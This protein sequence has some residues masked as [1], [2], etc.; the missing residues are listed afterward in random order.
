V[1]DKSTPPDDA[2]VATVR[3]A[4]R[5]KLFTL[6]ACERPFHVRVNVTV[7][8]VGAGRLQVNLRSVI[9]KN[10]GEMV[11][12]IPSKLSAEHTAP[13]DRAAKE[14]EILKQGGESVALLF[15]EHFR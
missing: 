15:G 4:I 10:S 7:S 5:Q 13:E 14:A 12:D 9:Y 1:E 6:Q 2:R 3:D 8:Q 11:G